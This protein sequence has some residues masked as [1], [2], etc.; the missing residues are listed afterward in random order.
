MKTLYDLK[1]RLTLDDGYII[2]Y[3]RH[4]VEWIGLNY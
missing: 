3:A 2:F 1:E 4:K